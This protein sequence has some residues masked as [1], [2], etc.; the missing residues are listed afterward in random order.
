[1]K[2]IVV[3]KIFLYLGFFIFSIPLFSQG[4]KPPVVGQ[5]PVLGST[6][7]VVPSGSLLFG[8]FS[9]VTG[10][11][12]EIDPN[13]LVTPSGDIF[14]VNS[15]RSAVT[16]E[17]STN[18]SNSNIVVVTANPTP[19]TPPLGTIGSLD[20]SVYFDKTSVV[21]DKNNPATVRMG[22]ILTVGP[23]DTSESYTGSV[24]VI[25]SYQ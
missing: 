17:V 24:S 13:G 1:M 18:R 4:N 8:K 15:I 23:E 9:K 20:L 11:T 21:I 10:G 6:L 16:F 2:D 14:L 19:L 5:P 7:T 22:G 3:N 12:I 25:F